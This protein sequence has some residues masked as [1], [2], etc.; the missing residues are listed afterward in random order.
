MP[1]GVRGSRQ[2]LFRWNLRCIFYRKQN[3]NQTLIP[4]AVEFF[5]PRPSSTEGC[6]AVQ[7]FCQTKS[8]KLKISGTPETRVDGIRYEKAIY[9]PDF[10]EVLVERRTIKNCTSSPYQS[11]F[12]IRIS[13]TESTSASTTK[14]ILNSKTQDVSVSA[15]FDFKVF[16]GGGSFKHS[17]K[18]EVSLSEGSS[19][20]YSRT[21]ERTTDE[22]FT[23]APQKVVT[24][25]FQVFS[26]QGSMKFKLDATADGNVITNLENIALASNV[27]SEDMRKFDIDG[28][29][30][31][32]ATSNMYVN[33]TERECTEADGNEL[34][35][36]SKG[37][38]YQSLDIETLKLSGNNGIL[39]S[40]S[41]TN[42]QGTDRCSI[43]CPE[44]E[45]A[46]CEDASGYGT[47]SCQCQSD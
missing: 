8:G 24:A 25:Y 6:C 41:A 10:T 1:N 19:N 9:N 5:V 17:V 43:D 4:R 22:R 36:T 29:I 3:A 37:S 15:K 31:A 23:V 26:M 16:G 40:C 38:V 32:V 12:K 46:Q 7:R 45:S 35:I 28:K 27:L 34:R 30:E 20:S 21:V 47:P 11:N 14:R 39:S 42:D 13:A 2:S 33:L 18:Q 44:G